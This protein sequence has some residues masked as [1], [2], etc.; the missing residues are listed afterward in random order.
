MV[1]ARSSIAS[2]GGWSL[3]NS[4]EVASVGI[5]RGGGVCELRKVE[6][7]LIVGSAWAELR[8]SAIVF[9]RFWAESERGKEG[10]VM[11]DSSRCWGARELGSRGSVLRWP[12]RW[13]GGGRRA[14]RGGVAREGGVQREGKW[15]QG[16]AEV[17]REAVWEAGGGLQPPTVAAAPLSTG[18][19]EAERVRGGRRWVDLFA[20]SKNSRDPTVK[21]K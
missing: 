18:G 4:G 12:Q 11:R 19:G 13:R 10:K 21:L 5:G 2:N 9:R 3:G 15:V 20:N 7:E 8:W 1:G 17:P 16:F 14:R 6:A